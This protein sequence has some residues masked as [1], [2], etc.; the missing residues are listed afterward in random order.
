[1]GVP[2]FSLLY[3][4]ALGKCVSKIASAQTENELRAAAVCVKLQ[5]SFTADSGSGKTF[6]QVWA[7]DANLSN[8]FGECTVDKASAS[9]ESQRRV[10]VSAAKRCLRE[11]KHAQVFKTRYGTF[12]RCVSRYTGKK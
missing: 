2:A 5:G 8:G 1:M 10:T 6:A 4:S 3:G 11:L 12:G 9:A 7:S